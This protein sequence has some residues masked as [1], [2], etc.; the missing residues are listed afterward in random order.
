MT[1]PRSRTLGRAPLPPDP[2]SF[3]A[4]GGEL[5]AEIRRITEEAVAAGRWRTPEDIRIT[6]AALPLAY[7]TYKSWN[8]IV[9]A[10]PG[11]GIEARLEPFRRTRFD[12]MP[13]GFVATSERT[14]SL[15][16]DLMCTKGLDDAKDRF[17][18]EVADVVFGADIAYA[19]L[20]STL[21]TSEIAATT[22]TEDETPKI[23]LTPQQYAAII[24]HC[25][26]RFDVV[27]L[28]NNHILDCGEEGVRTTL[29]HL[30]AD[31]VEQVGVNETEADA[32]RPRITCLKGLRIGWV[33]HTFSVNFMPFPADKPWLVNMTPM[34]LVPDPDVSGIEAQVRACR[35]AGC[36]LVFVSLHW[37]LE[38][39]L[40]PHP[41]QLRWAHRFAEAGADAVIGHHPH[42]PQPVEIY[43]PASDPSRAVPILYSLGNLTS[44]ISHP[45]N[46][47]SL[48]ARLRL[49]TGMLGGMRRTLVTGV[50]LTPV[51]LLA[52]RGPTACVLKLFPAT[53]LLDGGHDEVTSA[54]LSEVGSYVDVVLGTGWRETARSP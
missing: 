42:V 37:G 1:P 13:E 49:S 22:F 28:A 46:V 38:F 15:S 52:E 12:L 34:H 44:L 20:E 16:G 53:V 30:R 54:Y 2:R 19:N 4:F 36:D 5:G 41:D 26:R 3:I 10:M 17:Y 18:E 11:S 32:A 47:A 39:E 45:S 43:R 29:A 8:P 33:A 31:G 48:V 51:V 40:Y 27:Q 14:M 24:G 7:W 23:N 6:K 25:G 21:T 35:E 50:D 9:R